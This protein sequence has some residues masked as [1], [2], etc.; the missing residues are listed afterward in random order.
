MKFDRNPYSEIITLYIIISVYV[1]IVSYTHNISLQNVIS[2]GIFF[3]KWFFKIYR[4]Q[5]YPPWRVCIPLHD[6]FNGY[7]VLQTQMNTTPTCELDPAQVAIHSL[8]NR[9][10]PSVNLCTPNDLF[11]VTLLS[12]KICSLCSSFDLSSHW[13]HCC[14]SLLSIPFH[15]WCSIPQEKMSWFS[16]NLSFPYML[17]SLLEDLAGTKHSRYFNSTADSLPQRK[18]CYF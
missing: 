5:L 16:T 13:P 6:S 4:R 2:W 9:P 17:V 15:Y 8:C 7:T 18:R 14:P 11:L 1:A 10:L 3:D 12:V